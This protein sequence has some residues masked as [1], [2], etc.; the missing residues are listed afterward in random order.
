VEVAVV[1]R[2]DLLAL[3]RRSPS[4]GAVIVGAGDSPLLSDR[5]GGA[6]YVCRGFVCE[7]PTTAAD[8]LAEQL[9]V[10]SS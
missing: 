3:A 7:L 8:I 5:P 4:P 2:P 1:D 10:R 9:G 6:A